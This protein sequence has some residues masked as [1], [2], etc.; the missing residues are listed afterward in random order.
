MWKDFLVA[1][2]LMMVLEG[3]WPF[4]DPA[5]MRRALLNITEQE[6]QVLRIMGFISMLAGVVL[7]HI[8]N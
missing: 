2:C 5:S 8:I 3:I 4:L 7:L 6:D 1:V